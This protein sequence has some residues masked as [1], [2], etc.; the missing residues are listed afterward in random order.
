MHTSSSIPQPTK[1]ALVADVEFGVLTK[2]GDCILTGICR[3]SEALPL[4]TERRCRHAPA[5]FSREGERHLSCFF[6]RAL[7]RPC[8]RAAFFDQEDFGLP[9]SVPLPAFVTG[10]LGLPSDT[11]IAPGLLPIVKTAEGYGLH[12]CFC[13]KADG[14]AQRLLGFSRL[15]PALA[16]SKTAPTSNSK[17]GNTDD[18]TTL[19]FSA[20]GQVAVDG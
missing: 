20:D 13:E 14:D 19:S 7:M 4:S 18:F 11:V 9:L 2:D 10:A 12:L 5:V 1:K 6:P 8:V 17:S 16:S 3:V 15:H